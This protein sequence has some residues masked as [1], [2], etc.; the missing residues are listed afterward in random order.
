MVNYEKIRE[1]NGLMTARDF[2]W[3]FLG[4]ILGI[5]FGYIVGRLQ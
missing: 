3:W 4:I 1:E 5:L 2:R